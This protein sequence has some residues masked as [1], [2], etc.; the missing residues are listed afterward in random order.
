M[1]NI[2]LSIILFVTNVFVSHSQITASTP[3]IPLNFPNAFD[4]KITDSNKYFKD[5]YNTYNPW[6][7]T[8][9]YVNGNTE[10][11]IT[12]QKVEAVYIPSG[13]FNI[14]INCYR[15]LLN[16]GYYYQENGIIKTNHLT[17]TNQLKAPLR[18]YGNYPFPTKV[19]IYYDEIDKPQL[20]GTYVELT[21]LPG[22][23]TQASWVLDPSYRRNFSVPD[24]VIL[25]KL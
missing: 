25:T 18:C 16:G 23:T 8:W 21:L 5:V 9:K 17:Y 6:I 11:R 14:P 3:I 2:F 20:R 24:N 22:S 4:Y 12:I 10:F 19:R 1:K 7:G 13:T 15:D